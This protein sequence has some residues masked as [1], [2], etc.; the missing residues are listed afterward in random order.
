MLG[1][2]HQAGAGKS[3]KLKECVWLIPICIVADAGDHTI[4]CLTL[5]KQGEPC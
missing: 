1:R 3:G 4:F 5:L 2:L